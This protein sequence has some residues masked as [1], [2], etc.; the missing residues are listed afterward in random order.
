V[1]K[2]RYRLVTT[3]TEFVKFYVHLD[4]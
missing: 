2:T 3:V 1:V 4:T